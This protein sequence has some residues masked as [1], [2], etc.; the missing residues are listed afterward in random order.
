LRAKI[1][2]FLNIETIAKLDKNSKTSQITFRQIIE[3]LEMTLLPIDKRG[4]PEVTAS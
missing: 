1:D 3:L 2:I 4:C